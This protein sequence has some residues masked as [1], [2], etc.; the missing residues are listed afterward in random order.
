MRIGRKMLALLL[1]VL[2]VMSLLPTAF[3]A[4]PAPLTIT[5]VS[6]EHFENG[7]DA[8]V[9][10]KAAN[11]SSK[12]V[13]ADLI[14]ALYD[15]DGTMRDYAY[16]RDMIPQSGERT[17]G[18][19]L[20][21]PASGSFSMKAFAWDSFT[22]QDL[23][24]NVLEIDPAVQPDPEDIAE[25]VDGALKK[26]GA[27]ILGQVAEPGV[28]SIGG[29]WT[30][31][32][33]VR[34]GVKVPEGYY[35]GYYAKVQKTVQ[36]A[37]GI[38]DQHKYTENSRVILG[39]TAIG[40]DAK[41]VGGYD[42]TAA[43]ANYDQTVWQGIN[44]PIFAL[45]ALD[46][47]HYEI[48]QNTDV[49]MQ[50]TRQQYV[51][52]ILNKQTND[53]GWALGGGKADPDMTGMALQALAPYQSQEK[54]KQAIGK[55]LTCLSQMQGADGGYKSWGTANVESNCQVIV[56]LT[57]L[58][59]D[60][61]TDPRFIKGENSL[62]DAFF[63][64]ANEDGSFN[65]TTSTNLMASEQ[66]LYTLAALHRFY[67]KETSLYDMSDV[68]LEGGGQQPGEQ[69]GTVTLSIEKRTIGKGDVLSPTEVA[70]YEGDSA[71][72]LLKREMDARKYDYSATENVQYESVY[73]SSIEGDGEFNHGSGSGWMYCVNDVFPEFG[74]SK[75]VLKDG[76]VLRVRYT[77]DYG[78]DVRIALVERLKTVVSEAEET[79]S[80]GSYTQESEKNLQDALNAANKIIKDEN[81]QNADTKEEL[82]ISAQI[83][84]VNA[85]VKALE[86]DDGTEP[87][88]S[89]DIPADWE[90][91]IWL[92]SDFQRLSV[93]GTYNIYARR[94]PELVKD[95]INN[96][97]LTL[98]PMHY[99]IVEG[100]D[101]VSVDQDGMVTALKEGVAVI[102][103]RYDE[104]KPEWSDTTY[105]AC[106][107]V[108][109]AYMTVEVNNDPADVPIVS[110]L[111][112][113][114]QDEQNVYHTKGTTFDTV[115]FTEG[116]SVPYT[117][118]AEAGGA[119]LDV[120]CNGK[121]VTGKDGTYTANLEN[122]TNVIQIT[123]TKDGKTIMQAYSIDAR[124]IEIT[125]KNQTS[126][127][128][129]LQAGDTAAISFKGIV[130]PVSKLATI[131][132][133]CF[134]GG[135]WGNTASGVQ[136]TVNG[137]DVF[138]RCSQWDL[139][140]KNTI[141]YTFKT[142]GTY[143]FTDGCIDMWWWGSEPGTHQTMTGPGD[144]NLNADTLHAKMGMM[145]NFTIPVAEAANRPATSVEVSPATATGELKGDQN[146]I[147]LTAAVLPQGATNKN[148]TWS[149]SDDEIAA[150]DDAGL[151]RC[152]AVGEAV[153]TATTVDGEFTDSATITVVEEL[154][155]NDG[156]RAA[157]RG[158]IAEVD[159]LNEAEYTADSWNALQETKKKAKTVLDDT[160]ALKAA[161][162]EAYAALEQAKKE[163]V[164]SELRLDVN[165]S[166]RVIHPGDT[167]TV[168]LGGLPTPQ[169]DTS[170]WVNTKK[171]IYSSNIPEVTE[172]TSEEGKD[173]GELLQ[174]LTF[175][176]PE[177]TTPGEYRLTDGKI[178]C[179]WVVF[180]QP[181]MT[182]EKDYYTGQMPE[183]RI[184][185][186][187][188]AQEGQVIISESDLDANDYEIYYHVADVDYVYQ[189]QTVDFIS[190]TQ[191]T[192]GGKTYD[193]KNKQI[194]VDVQV[195]GDTA[196]ITLNG[197]RT[198]VEQISGEWNVY[199]GGTVQLV[200][201]TDI[202]AQSVVR[203]EEGSSLKNT[204]T[205]TGLTSG[206]YHLTGG[207]IY[208]KANQWS[209]GHNFGDGAG[210]V[211]E[212]F[213]GVLPDI[214][215]VVP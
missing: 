130:I 173:N 57:A 65:H 214:T 50:A 123:A 89:G 208:E 15:S 175:T 32:G 202:D 197:V 36:N 86:K 91:D 144:A 203:S 43:L 68:V 102:R 184:E 23:L 85:A 90:N 101:V 78:S 181:M 84:A 54:V 126:P 31:L 178:Y 148:V 158:L 147:Q 60:P 95:P 13:T 103:V 77:T 35:D 38:L 19:G 135:A 162:D 107:P 80:G 46:S 48:G 195:A 167:V 30:V 26:T 193:L 176:V 5:Q 209:P 37:Q 100:N 151:V 34:G 111:D 58:G 122:R 108:N 25:K 87:P 1:S 72:T 120:T 88:A 47:H 134:G 124:K 157:L 141:T 8:H 160:Q 73:I 110:D 210:V 137:E 139:A 69:V 64:F 125:V 205:I 152:K 12:A 177:S 10:L 131:Y 96:T 118:T 112:R 189:G 145:P 2:M 42:L 187:A 59:I 94:L 109:Y 212:G 81:Y 211:T 115:Y 79:L 185:V 117:F 67:S 70:L 165:I 83:A 20:S 22:S 16:V 17:W 182:E 24:S 172:V 74:L 201:Q 56:G 104:V 133:P 33:L 28:A 3:A 198:P 200:Y 164:A 180:P 99:E 136:Y 106:S 40:K 204:L 98:P 9:E 140:T 150:V 51:D 215:I 4:S 44:G 75:C 213:F 121:T 171:T 142:A 114:N 192:A 97:G 105:G 14:L 206:I 179:Q 161:V 49:E 146:T 166:P 199:A 183:I 61:H 7:Q 129:A 138:G 11:S 113:L 93:G 188:E 76:D 62:V 196:T 186:T 66:A 132:N 119:E 168:T 45:L 128:E 194:T 163:L 63:S 155:A 149:S 29:D 169:P 116:D 156:E 170:F 53:G 18:A 154:P 174:T 21:I 41:A 52:Y 207:T 143:A 6:V 27:Y 92:N 71:W 39:L 127:G 55:A 153:I 191:F 159:L 82:E 190:E